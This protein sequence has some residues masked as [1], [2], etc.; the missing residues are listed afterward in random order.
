MRI[1]ELFVSLFCI[2]SCQKAAG[3]VVMPIARHPTT[4]T[5]RSLPLFTKPRSVPLQ[6]LTA[7]SAGNSNDEH[8]TLRDRLRQVTGFSFTAFRATLR[9]ITGISL[10]ALYAS[11]VATTS[12]FVRNT[13]KVILS[14]FPTW[15]RG[16]FV[17]FSLSCP[18]SHYSY[19]TFL[20]SLVSILF[21][22]IFGT[23]LCTTV[24]DS[25][26]SWT[27]RQ[28]RSSAS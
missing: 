2:A 12:S 21:A 13:M 9:G 15:V 28:G 16:M 26:N 23:L 1:L 20:H 8:L 3:F 25:W 14:V 27:C 24:C 18:L 22:A 4:M 17:V 5:G 19:I 10:T 6:I 11:A 7:G